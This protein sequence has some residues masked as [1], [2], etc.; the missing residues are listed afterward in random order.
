ME[1]TRVYPAGYPDDWEHYHPK[2]ETEDEAHEK[3]KQLAEKDGMRMP[4]VYMTHKFGEVG[5]RA[6]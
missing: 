6:V 2:A 5:P 3:A 4:M 1:I